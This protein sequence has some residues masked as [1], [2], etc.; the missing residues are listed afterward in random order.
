MYSFVKL[1]PFIYNCLL[2]NIS[3]SEGIVLSS[4]KLILGIISEKFLF[5]EEIFV[6]RNKCF[7]LL[8]E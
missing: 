3:L 4:F 1:L 6:T 7:F 5:K 2:Y 8:N